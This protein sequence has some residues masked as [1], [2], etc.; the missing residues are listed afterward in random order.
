[1]VS[2]LPSAGKITLTTIGYDHLQEPLMC[3]AEHDAWTVFD[4]GI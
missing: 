1:V 3:A 2:P 4:Q